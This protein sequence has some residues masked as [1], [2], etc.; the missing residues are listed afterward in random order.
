MNIL[1]KNGEQLSLEE[2]ADC[3]RCAAAISYGLARNA[4]AAK[5]NGKLV[6]IRTHLSDGDTVEMLSNAHGSF[7]L[8]IRR[9]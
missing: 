6:D 3:L 7:I 2:G 1:L 9:R 5:V 8:T 4:V